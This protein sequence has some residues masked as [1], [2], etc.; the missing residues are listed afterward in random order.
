MSRHSLVAIAGVLAGSL[1]LSGPVLGSTQSTTKLKGTVG[2]GFTITLKDSHGKKVTKVKAGKYAFVISD[3]A[4][5]HSFVLE[6]ESGGKFEKELTSVGFTGTKTV[7]VTLK[8]GKFKFYCAPHE[9]TMFGFFT[10][11]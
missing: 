10:V 9:A 6:Q 4:S 2:P 3:K 1:A 11:T 8:K 5:I 7:T